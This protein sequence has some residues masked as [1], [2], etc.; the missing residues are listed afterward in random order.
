MALLY[1]DENISPTTQRMLTQNG[2]D[3]VHAYDLGNRAIS[4]AEHLWV[5]AEAGRILIT[6]NRHDFRDLHRLWTALNIWGSLDQKHAGILTSWGDVDEVP[7]AI[8]V[9]A[10]VSEQQN[11]DSQMWEWRPRQ[12]DWRPFGW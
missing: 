9:N 8:T 2:H 3:V 5:A 12:E 10:F 4:D 11:I 1:L 7:W 6:F